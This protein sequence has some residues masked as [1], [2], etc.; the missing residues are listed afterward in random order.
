MRTKFSDKYT[1]DELSDKCFPWAAAIAFVGIAIWIAMCV[2]DPWN[3]VLVPLGISVLFLI[4][5]I[6]LMVACGLAIGIAKVIYLLEGA[7]E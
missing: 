1:V 4:G 7:E 5:A 6:F 2:A 3:I